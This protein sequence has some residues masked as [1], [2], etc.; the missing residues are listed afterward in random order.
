MAAV[1]GSRD[2]AV[3]PHEVPRNDIGFWM[4]AA[5]QNGQVS[6]GQMITSSDSPSV[7]GSFEYKPVLLLERVPKEAETAGTR[8]RETV[9]LSLQGRVA[10]AK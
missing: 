3:Q 4:L 10:G 9:D 6:S 2:A 5:V 8:E 1:S 7:S